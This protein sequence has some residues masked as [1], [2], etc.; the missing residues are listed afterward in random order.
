M[1]NYLGIE[2]AIK[3][4]NNKVDYDFTL[5]NL[6]EL[7]AFGYVSTVFFYEGLAKFSLMSVD[8]YC[9]I[10]GYFKLPEIENLISTEP[11]YF[12]TCLLSLAANDYQDSYGDITVSLIPDDDSDEIVVLDRTNK[13]LKVS[14]YDYDFRLTEIDE[15]GELIEIN[16]IAPDAVRISKTEIDN[17]LNNT[18]NLDTDHSQKIAELEKQLSKAHADNDLLRKK[19]DSNKELEPN[20]QAAIARLLNVLFY[21]ADYDITA[22]QGTTNTKIQKLSKEM[23]TPVGEKFISKWIKIVN[24]EK[25]GDEG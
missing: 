14:P 4:I 23:G 16:S 5:S 24:S 19:L 13:T 25:M 17:W 11:I 6:K 1:F 9:S 21:K 8:A 15:Q 20:S 7:Q 3:Y 18:T 2:Q 12:D 22:H 10:N